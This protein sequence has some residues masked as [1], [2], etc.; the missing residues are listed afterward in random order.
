MS[1]YLLNPAEG[2]DLN[3]LLT[4]WA[5]VHVIVL[6][7]SHMKGNKGSSWT[8]G[9]SC[10]FNLSIQPAW[11][12]TAKLDGTSFFFFSPEA[13]DFWCIIWFLYLCHAHTSPTLC[14]TVLS[15]CCVKWWVMARDRKRGRSSWI[16]NT[17]ISQRSGISRDVP[18]KR[19]TENI[20]DKHGS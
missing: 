14:A 10:Y 3:H 15:Q 8:N 5:N 4:H 20:S 2:L 1:K 19:G 18:A 6:L 7:R 11:F 16:F 12:I 9:L 13:T 17:A